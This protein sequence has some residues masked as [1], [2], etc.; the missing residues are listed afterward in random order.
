[1]AQLSEIFEK[2][3]ADYCRQIAGLDLAKRQVTLGVQRVD[4]GVAVPFLGETYRVSGDGMAGAQGRRPDYRI[5]VVLA[6]Y[7]LLCP[8]QLHL[9]DEW[10]SFKDF[11]NVSHFT[12]VNYFASDTERAITRHYS[13][14]REALA[15][16]GKALGGAVPAQAMP[17]DV[18]MQF[19]A[20]P[21]LSLLMLFNDQDEMFG[22]ECKVLFQ[23]QA[24]FYLDPESLAVT[25]A[26]LAER[27]VSAGKAL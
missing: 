25:G 23:K 5:C 12:N 11:R 14:R 20:L 6:K 10:V 4:G 8:V 19:V 7:L 18:A 15:A 2:H 24:E 22:A 1:M 27:L 9:D 26:L 21:R 13:G 16:A 17:Y 3:Y